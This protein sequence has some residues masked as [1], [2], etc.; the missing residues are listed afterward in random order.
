MEAAEREMGLPERSPWEPKFSRDTLHVK[1]MALP[2]H[3]PLSSISLALFTLEI[4]L[5]K[6]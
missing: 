2:Y 6:N 4:N 5:T 1:F 3:D